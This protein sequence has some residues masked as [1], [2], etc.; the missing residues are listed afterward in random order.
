VLQFFVP[1]LDIELKLKGIF[2]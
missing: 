2:S 1:P